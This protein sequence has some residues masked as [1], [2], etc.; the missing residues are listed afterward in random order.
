MSRAVKVLEDGNWHIRHLISH[1][2]NTVAV[3]KYSINKINRFLTWLLSDIAFYLSGG[4]S[5]SRLNLHLLKR[6]AFI[7]VKKSEKRRPE[8]ILKL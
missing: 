6:K 8:E 5:L 2:Y 4:G 3:T 1:P 7:L